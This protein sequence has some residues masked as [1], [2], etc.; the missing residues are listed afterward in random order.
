MAQGPTGA[1]P[2]PLRQQTGTTGSGV[3]RGRGRRRGHA[4]GRLELAAPIDPGA[5]AITSAGAPPL[6]SPPVLRTGDKPRTRPP[7]GTL[8]DVAVGAVRHRPLPRHSRSPTFS[9]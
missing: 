6:T 5:R 4:G 9:R 2:P 3:A 7:H 8:G 1:Q